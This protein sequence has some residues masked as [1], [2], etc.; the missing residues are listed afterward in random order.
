MTLAIA[1]A[2]TAIA[3]TPFPSIG[4]AQPAAAAPGVPNAPVVLYSEDFENSPDAGV[5]QQITEYESTSPQYSGGGY[6]ASNY[7]ARATNCNGFILSSGSTYPARA[8][9]NR[10]SSFYAVR[11]LAP[12]LGTIGG[13]PPS[14]NSVVAAYTSGTGL[15]SNQVQFATTDAI[16]LRTPSR[17]LTFS[18]DAAAANCFASAPLLQ[19]YIKNADNTET[20]LGGRINPCNTADPRTTYIAGWT[21]G[22]HYPASGSF[23]AT[24][25]SVGVVMRNVNGST[26]GNDGAFDN[27]QLLDATPQL[28]KSFSVPNP[29]SGVSTLTFTLTNTSDLATKLGWGATDEL[30][31]GLQVASPNNASTTCT[32]GAISAAGGS[33]N[34]TLRGDLAGDTAHLTSCTFTVDVV[35]TSPVAQGAAAQVFQNC[36]RNLSDIIGLDPPANCASQSFP[37]V[38]Q[39][40]VSKSSTASTATREGD[41][42]SYTVTATNTGGSAYTS[43]EPATVTDDLSGVLDDATFNNDASANAL[44]GP[45]FTSPILSWSGPLAA[46]A[47]VTL[48]YSV[49]VSL[50]GDAVLSNTACIPAGQASADPCTTVSTAITRAPSI[51]LVKS[52]SPL[53]VVDGEP[54]TY[55]FVVTNSGNVRLNSP[56]VSED[57]FNGANPAGMSVLDCGV[58]APTTLMP[59]AQMICTATYT[60]VQGDVD[61]ASLSNTATSS[62]V[63][64]ASGPVSSPPQTVT[65]PAVQDP[66]L[67]MAKSAGPGG[68][69]AANQLVTY[70]FLIT[71]TGNVTLN[72]IAVREGTFSGTGAMSTPSC[73]AGASSIAPGEQ[74][75]CTAT[76]TLTQDDV[77]SGGLENS[78]TAAGSSPA[79]PTIVSAPD[80]ANFRIASAPSLSVDKSAT[81]GPLTRIGQEVTYSFLLTNT[82]NVTLDEVEVT[83]RSFT[84]TGTITMPSCAVL[85][86]APAA[87]TSCT[88]QY[89]LTQADVDAGQIQNTASASGTPPSGA[90]VRSSLSNASVDITPTAAVTMRASVSR[91]EVTLANATMAFQFE[92]TN[93]G[94]STLRSLVVNPNDFSGT[95][96]LGT[97]TCQSASLA[98]GESTLCS[99]EYRVTAADAAV[100]SVSLSAV[101]G[102]TSASGV[103]LFTELDT[104]SVTIVP[105]SESSPAG[106]AFTGSSSTG[107]I[108]FA[109]G[110]ILGG[111]AL[112]FIGTR[113]VKNGSATTNVIRIK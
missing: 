30:S 15:T 3:V 100:G 11:T 16:D 96:T 36:A 106:L 82:G 50:A 7:W 51:R 87:S 107:G 81:S 43:A 17:F 23:I 86:L 20:A 29:V 77:D 60:P 8:C 109:L 108:L 97:I 72:S 34:I 113:F 90:R 68:F 54:I 9:D 92:M 80:E 65:L 98:P 57:S 28:D 89:F 32:N 88:A 39:L 27:I 104:A 74:I 13:T 10:S 66:S 85:T 91:S 94:E 52:A 55:T 26:G 38:A 24:G 84:G 31:S 71:N 95:G 33:G 99:V 103:S 58:P 1:L 79:G 110:G 35:P 67:S 70:S 14:T 64:A 40:S 45:T 112:L 4:G 5:P 18:V 73:P 61:G 102:A 37:P 44:S 59:G 21:R 62:G 111:A 19:F 42:V 22:G 75:T 83:E 46:G 6:T 105:I 47:S 2:A 49:T 93:T 56:T 41:V 63:A 78:A 48:K 12:V 101:A 69:T 76:Y 25:D 53:S